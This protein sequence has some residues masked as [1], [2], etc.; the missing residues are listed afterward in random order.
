MRFVRYERSGAPR[1][2]VLD[3]DSVIDL[4]DAAPAGTPV[5]LLAAFSDMTLL[6]AAGDA[7]IA[8][9]RTALA[10]SPSARALMSSE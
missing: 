8:A 7:G 3:G 2:G 5:S 6:I 1:L 4:L 9:A 10:A